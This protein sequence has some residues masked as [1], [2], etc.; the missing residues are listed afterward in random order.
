MPRRHRAS[1]KESHVKRTLRTAISLVMFSAVAILGFADHAPYVGVQEASAEKEKD[2]A[3][4]IACGK[5]AE[6]QCG[7]GDKPCWNS[8]V[9]EQPARGAVCSPRAP[10]G[11]GQ[12][13]MNGICAT[14]CANDN[15]CAKNGGACHVGFC[16]RRS[17]EE[18]ASCERACMACQKK[19]EKCS[20]DADRCMSKC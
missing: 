11:E 1:A 4:I 15:D 13:C 5:A 6:K 16:G 9:C 14:A 17:P 18:M 8:C 7:G 19:M 12:R 3:C 10:C 2:D 20:A